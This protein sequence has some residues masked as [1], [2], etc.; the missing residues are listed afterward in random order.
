MPDKASAT[1]AATHIDSI[2]QERRKFEC[3]EHFRQQAHIKS[4]EEYE[5]IYRESVEQ[6]EQF[7]DVLPRNCIGSKN[8]TTFWS[9]IARGP[10]GSPEANSI[11]PTIVSIAMF[12][13]GARIKR[14]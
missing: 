10:S 1:Q 14:R 7:W 6:P 2:L 13:P 9:G 12:K 11:S 3:P 8:G 4:L 5:R